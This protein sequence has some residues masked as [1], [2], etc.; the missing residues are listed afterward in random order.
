MARGGMQGGE[1]NEFTGLTLAE[2]ARQSLTIVGAA[3]HT[4][5]LEMVGSAFTQSG[6]HGTSDFANVLSSLMGKAAL[7]GWAEAEETFEVWTQEGVLT[8]FKP[9]KRVGLGLVETLPEVAEGAD[10]TYGTIGDRGETI[11][12]ATFGR[13][14]RITRQAIINDDLQLFTSLP[15]KA[16]RAAKRTIGNL[17]YA[18]LTGNPNLSDGVALFHASHNNLAA[19]GGAP[20]VATLGAGRAAM[21]TQKDSS[22]E[23]CHCLLQG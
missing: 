23:G 1:R 14:M 15:S 8:D 18:V 9:T 2:L 13:L 17:V 4:N 11:A 7:M 10:Y 21:R 22:E 19:S 3:A 6:A 12:L 20:S 5:R 16:G